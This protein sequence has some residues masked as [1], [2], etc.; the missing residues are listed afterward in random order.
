MPTKRNIGSAA[1]TVDKKPAMT[2][3]NN[4][5]GNKVAEFRNL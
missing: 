5:Q 2:T 3:A 1:H 4:P